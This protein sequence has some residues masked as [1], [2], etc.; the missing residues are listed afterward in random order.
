MT[1]KNTIKMKHLINF[2]FNFEINLFGFPRM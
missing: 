2:Y 1:F